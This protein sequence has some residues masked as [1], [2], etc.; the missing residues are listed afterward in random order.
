VIEDC[1]KRLSWSGYGRGQPQG[2]GRG[3]FLSLHGYSFKPG[4]SFPNVSKV[5]EEIS[6]EVV[7]AWEEEDEELIL[8][9]RCVT[10]VGK[11]TQTFRV[12]E[13]DSV[14]TVGS[15]DTLLR[16]TQLRE[17]RVEEDFSSK[18]GCMR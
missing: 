12:R 16:V 14:T 5:T 18:V 10:S 15:L 4:C 9:L 17:D 7:L 6:E 3:R 2:R 11:V 8:V 13:M 1:N